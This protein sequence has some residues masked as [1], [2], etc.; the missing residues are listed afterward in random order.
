MLID[1]ILEMLL[2]A[3]HIDLSTVNKMWQRIL[4]KM[5]IQLEDFDYALQITGYHANSNKFLESLEGLL[6]MTFKT[7]HVLEVEDSPWRLVFVCKS[8][9]G[10]QSLVCASW[11][12]TGPDF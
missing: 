9:E 3:N 11:Y 1:K 10:K 12:H 7:V 6:K 4:V 2:Y 8:N 5:G